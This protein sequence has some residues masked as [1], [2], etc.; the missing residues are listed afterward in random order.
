MYIHL[1][2]ISS[3]PKRQGE[4]MRKHYLIVGFLAGLMLS[5]LLI[6]AYARDF[7]NG[8]KNVQTV[9]G[10]IVDQNN[11]P[12]IAR[13]ELWYADLAPI[14]EELGENI[15]D[16]EQWTRNLHHATFSTESGWYRLEAPVGKWLVR[17]SKGPEYEVK[18][19][20]VTV[21]ETTDGR[22]ESDGERMDWNLSHLYDM[23]SQG[24]YSGDLHVHSSHS[25][26]KNSVSQVAYS[27]Q[28]SDVD[29]AALTDHNTVAGLEE[30]AEFK[31]D[32]FLPLPGLEITTRALPNV[33]KN[34]ISKGFG[35]QNVIGVSELIGAKDA[36]NDSIWLRYTF[37]SWID[38]QAAIDEARTKGGLYML[39][40][41]FWLGGWPN[42][43]ISTWGDIHD[44]DAIEVWNGWPAPF[45]PDTYA[46]ESEM[47]NTMAMQVWFEML[48]AGNRVAGWG[49]SDTH[50]VYGLA[51]NNQP[52]RF[53]TVSGNA[54]TY[55]HSEDLSMGSVMDSLKSGKAFVTSGWGPILLVDSNSREPGDMIEVAENG[56]LPL[57]I[58]VLSNRPLGNFSDGIRIIQGGQVVKALQ[59]VEGAMTMDINTTINLSTKNDTWVIVQAF[60]QEPSMAITNPIYLDL[61]PYG[62]W[63][64]S[65]WAFPDGAKNWTATKDAL[66]AQ[67]VPDIS[68]DFDEQQQA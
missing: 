9:Y 2:I 67:T 18:E 21:N 28:A 17:V 15:S 53:R 13:A 42:G 7:Y 23:E 14:T 5:S 58:Q 1:I 19:A 65:Q 35:H 16:K 22:S 11:N 26:G 29:F 6:S 47:A 63:V 64:S 68:L 55:V 39:N 62:Q 33:V 43:T 32:E 27:M 8:E 12:L 3:L 10:K 44:Y 50:D 25:D 4:G 20:V 51:G 41:P 60:N 57:H 37:S 38:V 49:T 36:K 24:W 52:A 61:Q 54:R 48:N 34:Q 46:N 30:W 45:M 59:T 56:S 66:P 40:H 31:S